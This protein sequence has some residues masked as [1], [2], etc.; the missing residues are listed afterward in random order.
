MKDIN[1]APT[2]A[3]K[4]RE[5]GI[6]QDDLASFI[7]VSKAS[8]SKWE[9]G[10]S[11]PDIVFLPKLAA[12]F[13]IS[14]DELM[15]YSP[16]LTASDIRKTYRELAARFAGEDFKTVYRDCQILIQKYFACFPF[17]ALMAI[18]LFNH[19][20]IITD[21]EEKN[22]LLREIIEICIRV[23]TESGD[24]SITRNSMWIESYCRLL[25]GEP[26]AIF[27]ILGENVDHHHFPAQTLI[28][29]AYAAVGK[30]EKAKEVAQISAFQNLLAFMESMGNYIN[31]HIDEFDKAEKV[32]NIALA[33]AEAVELEAADANSAVLLYA[34]GAH[35][36]CT[37]GHYDKAIELLWKYTDLCTKRFFPIRLRGGDLAN[38]DVIEAWLEESNLYSGIPRD[39]KIIKG[40]MF[41]DIIMS[42][43]FAA[44]AEYP[45]YKK[46]IF[47]F[48][49]FLEDEN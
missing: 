32:L 40:S 24:I 34:T 26:N 27:E 49:K 48:T 44:I 36:Y 18:L 37:N 21:E 30:P 41:N 47:E 43:M 29:Q 3:S 14:L 8:V 9:T 46:I 42:P 39:N 6:T 2:I 7:G 1:I 25:L 15:G 35:L 31:F 38:P 17:L 16:Q 23:K 10:Q 33:V 4:R 20:T 22:A 28:A 5:K 19:H 11:Y 13:N 45:E 12:F